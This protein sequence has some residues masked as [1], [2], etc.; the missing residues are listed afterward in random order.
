MSAL[1]NVQGRKVG[2]ETTFRGSLLKRQ[3]LSQIVVDVSKQGVRVSV[4]GRRIIAWTGNADELSLSDYWKTPDDRVLF[5][6]S[7]DCRY[8]FHRITIE[9][10][11][12]QGRVLE[13]SATKP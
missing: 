13:P 3:R 8:R 9:P 2:N 10:L 4:D 6:G 1:E 7:Y 5:V 12:G 11:A